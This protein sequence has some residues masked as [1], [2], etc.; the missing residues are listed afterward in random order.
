MYVAGSCAVAAAGLLLVTWHRLFGVA[1]GAFADSLRAAILYGFYGIVCV[2]LSLRWRRKRLSYVGW[3]LL[4]AAPFWL[5]HSIALG[6]WKDDLAVAGCLV[7]TAVV[8]LVLAWQHRSAVML[9]LQQIMLSAAG[10]FAAF[11]WLVRQG[12]IVSAN[13]PDDLVK[14]YN[15]QAFAAA[16][17]ALCAAVDDRP[18][19]PARQRANANALESPVAAGR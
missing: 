5:L 13:L 14:V 12:W 10:L 7:W 3:N 11:A 6:A 16:L 18:H 4:A 15:L 8:W 2:L 9:T 1:G 19:H 17:A